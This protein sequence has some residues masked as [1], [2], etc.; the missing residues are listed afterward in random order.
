[1]N[2]EPSNNHNRNPLSALAAHANDALAPQDR[3][4]ATPP[5]RNGEGHFRSEK[6]T[7]GLSQWALH[8]KG[9]IPPTAFAMLLDYV[10]WFRKLAL[11][12][13]VDGDSESA[14]RAIGHNKFNSV[15]GAEEK[16][17]EHESAAGRREVQRLV[18][19]AACLENEISDI[20]AT[21]V[22]EP[23]EAR[24]PSPRSLNFWAFL[25][26]A[27]FFCI[28]GAGAVA[29]IVATLLPFTQSVWLALMVSGVWVMLSV[30]LKIAAGA[31]QGVQRKILHWAIAVVGL[32]GA[33]IWLVGLV[34]TYSGD[35]NLND[36]GNG[37][38][39]VRSKALP[40]VGQLL[41]ELA[42]GF[43][44]LSGMFA[45]LNH[46]RTIVP[47]ES[48]RRISDKLARVNKELGEALGEVAKADGNLA[49]L[50]AS[51]ES[52]IAEGIAILR[53]RR[54]DAALLAELQRGHAD[55]QRLLAQFVA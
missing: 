14:V 27:V 9:G 40:F 17:F 36:L 35:I 31:L 55:N 41:A 32:I 12:H 42:V 16:K 25:L 15:W 10:I 38:L 45:V 7:S 26:C 2:N 47:N 33:I 13:P 1:M 18:A 48:R 53:L 23:V 11:V 34:V 49:E 6:P 3:F 19:D 44:C 54:A 22:Q 46:P 20:P 8:P 50:Q 21:V 30:A 5:M 4:S 37:G 24:L 51:R 52:F 43:A 39:L 29:N 28:S